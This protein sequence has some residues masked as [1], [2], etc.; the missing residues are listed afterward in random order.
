M[1]YVADLGEG[2]LSV[3]FAAIGC[4]P[5]GVVL[6]GPFDTE[7]EAIV[8]YVNIRAEEAAHSEVIYG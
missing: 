6:A 8:A 3:E 2:I 7:R 4:Q 1:W 5:H